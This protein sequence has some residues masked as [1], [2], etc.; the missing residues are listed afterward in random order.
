GE[1]LLVVV[2]ADVG[3]VQGHVGEVA[4]AAG[5]RRLDRRDVAEDLVALLDQQGAEVLEVLLLEVGLDLAQ[6]GLGPLD[7]V[8]GVVAVVVVLVALVG[9]D[10]GERGRGAALGGQRLAGRLAGAV[11]GGLPGRGP[12][13]GGGLFGRG[14]LGAR[15]LLL[16]RGGGRRRPRGRRTPLR[17]GLFLL[18]RLLG[19][20]RTS[21]SGDGSPGRHQ[22]RGGSVASPPAQG[23]Y[24]ATKRR[25]IAV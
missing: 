10:G 7:G 23:N 2:R 9:G 20:N 21:E 3:H 4:R 22:R 6:L 1:L 5:V 14:G 12:G 19:Q 11:G 13:G 16:P 8:L 17:R 18:G 24:P 15:G 25:S